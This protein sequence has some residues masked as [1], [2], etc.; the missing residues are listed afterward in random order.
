[1]VSQHDGQRSIVSDGGMLKAV[2]YHEETR[3]VT[4]DGGGVLC[5]K[6]WL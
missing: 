6:T 5:C 4:A 1:M 3:V 2:C